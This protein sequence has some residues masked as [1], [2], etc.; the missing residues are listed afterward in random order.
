MLLLLTFTYGASCARRAAHGNEMRQSWQASIKRGHHQ[1]PA[2]AIRAGGSSTRIAVLMR[3]LLNSAIIV[4]RLQS[5]SLARCRAKFREL[6]R[7]HREGIGFWK[8][9]SA[10]RVDTTWPLTR[11]SVS[12]GVVLA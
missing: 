11:V 7:N 10:C 3:F 12:H 8:W 1:R 9:R 5:A 4:A 6:K 2:V